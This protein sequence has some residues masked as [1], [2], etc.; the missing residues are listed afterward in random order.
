MKKRI[1][2]ISLIGLF[3]SCLNSNAQSNG[4]DIDLIVRKGIYLSFDDF[5]RNAPSI[6]KNFNIRDN[7][8]KT[9]E[10]FETFELQRFIELY[11]MN[12]LLYIEFTNFRNDTLRFD[13]RG[14][15]GF[16]TGESIF[17]KGYY[18]LYRIANFD[19]LCQLDFYEKK[20][21]FY[22]RQYHDYDKKMYERDHLTKKQPGSLEGMSS[23]EIDLTEK[24][25]FSLYSTGHFLNLKTGKIQYPFD[26]AKEVVK[27]IESDEQLFQEFTNDTLQYESMKIKAYKYFTLYKDRNPVNYPVIQ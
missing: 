15:W 23:I 13:L 18:G 12:K 3:I 24:P 25:Y 20:D 14:I 17:I 6:S 26:F 1:V 8:G 19:V 9:N 11:F 2:I 27:I 16:S 10:Y 21:F 5:I 4:G 22:E 7:R